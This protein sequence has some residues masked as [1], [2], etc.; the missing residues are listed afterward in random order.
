MKEKTNAGAH[1]KLHMAFETQGLADAKDGGGLSAFKG[2]L[3]H[4]LLVVFT[5]KWW[6]FPLSWL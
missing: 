6:F 5:Q 4:K 2:E 1:T 3:Q